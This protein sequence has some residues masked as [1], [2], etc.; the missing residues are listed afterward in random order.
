[1]GG[2]FTEAA[3]DEKDA[4]VVVTVGREGWS[5][6]EAEV[7]RALPA[8]K[9]FCQCVGDEN[10]PGAPTPFKSNLTVVY[11]L[12]NDRLHPTE[13]SRKVLQEISAQWG[14]SAFLKAWNLKMRGF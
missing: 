6:E 4:E 10:C 13:E 5:S 11:R 7:L 3:T 2:W 12:T 8:T 14:H 9:K 1:M